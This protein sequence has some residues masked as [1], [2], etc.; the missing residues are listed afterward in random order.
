MFSFRQKIFFSHLL[1]FLLFVIFLYPVVTTIMER[2]QA[3]SLR[4]RVERVILSVERVSSLTDII[5]KLKQTENLLFFRLS[6]F[7]PQKGFLYDSHQEV[8]GS[9]FESGHRLSYPE[10]EEALAKGVGYQVRYSSL[11]EQEMAYIAVPFFYHGEQL[12]LRAAF[13]YGQVID[14]THELTIAFLFIGIIILLLFSMLSWFI[15]HYFTSPVRK[16]LETIRPYQT[17]IEEHIPQIH[18]GKKIGQKDEFGQLAETLNSLSSRIELQISSLTQE[19]D[20]KSAIL[21]SLIEGVVVVDEKLTVIYMND[22]AALFLGL[23]RKELVGKNFAL[24]KQQ[25]CEELIVRAQKEKEPITIVLKP[26]RKQKK[27]FDAVAAPRGKKEKGAVLVLQDKTGLHKVIELGR[28]FIA[29]ASHELKTPITIIRGFAE[30]LHDHP[31]LSREVNREITGKIV[32]NCHRM[33]M[34]VR[35]LLTL[36]AVD[37]GLPRS[38]LRNCDLYDLLSQ[39]SNTILTVHHTADIQVEEIGEGPFI[40][41]LDSDLFLQALLNLFENAAKYSKPPAHIRAKVERKPKEFIVTIADQGQGIPAED[42]DR[43]FE[44]FF[45]VDKSH[46]RSLGGSGLGLSIVERIVEK[47]G[48]KIEVESTLGKGTTFWVTL[49]VERETQ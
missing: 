18:L 45:A 9:E 5:E 48:G 32:S 4:H 47:H 42:L 25:E 6:L 21:E 7:E 35:N 8:E 46:S 3:T 12:V 30:T 19:K 20:E 11:F 37:E 23:E 38:R 15:I 22:T 44:R 28:D 31:G 36:A 33:E 16:I 17:G 43:I 49:P 34:L 40:C 27:F 41:L 14:L 39:A 26:K 24:A 29:N 1:I 10:I 2:I 13:P